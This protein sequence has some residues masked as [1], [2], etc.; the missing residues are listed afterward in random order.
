MKRDGLHMNIHT[1]FILHSG[2]L[3]LIAFCCV[4]NGILMPVARDIVSLS[5]GYQSE[6]QPPPP[7]AGKENKDDAWES[8]MD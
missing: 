3:L 5:A 4:T 7:S 1:F 6:T 2:S 8:M